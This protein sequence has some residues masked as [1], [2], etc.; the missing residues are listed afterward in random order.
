[1]ALAIGNEIIDLL[2]IL[3]QESI[4]WRGTGKVHVPYIDFLLVQEFDCIF[5]PRWQRQGSRR[6]LMQLHDRSGRDH[7]ADRQGGQS[8]APK[9]LSEDLTPGGMLLHG[10][11]FR[12]DDAFLLELV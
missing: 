12:P 11:R 9:Y 1:M 10:G 7:R 3:L 5:N 2:Q 6:G 8:A 4:H